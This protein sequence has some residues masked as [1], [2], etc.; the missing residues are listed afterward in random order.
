MARC[1]TDTPWEARRPPKF[2]RFMAPAKPLPIEMPVTSTN[3]PATKWSAVISAPTDQAVGLDAEFRDLALGLDLRLGEMAALALA[4]VL[5]LGAAS[6]ELHG[7][8]AVLVG[9]ALATTWQVVELQHRHRNLLAVIRN[10]RVM[11][12]FFAITPERIG[13]PLRVHRSSP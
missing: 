7:G 6:A 4:T 13:D 5:G 2:H 10:R 3:W 1:E 8:V 9:G 11:P 12:S